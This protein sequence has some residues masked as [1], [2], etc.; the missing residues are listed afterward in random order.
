MAAK[1]LGQFLL[2]QGLIDR[3][4]LLDALEGQRAS[5]PLLGELAVACGM[6][7]GEQAQRI[8]ERQRREDLRFGDIAQS[9]GLLTAAQIETLLARQKAGSK[10]FGQILLEQGALTPDA[11]AEALKAHEAGRDEAID[12]L[13]AE[14][15]AH[16]AGAVMDNA[17]STCTRLFPRLLQTRCQFSSLVGADGADACRVTAHVRIDA[18]P[19]LMV[20]IGSD[21]ETTSNIGHAFLSLPAGE[22]DEALAQ[23][24]LGEL[25]NV[26]MGYV[27]KD[28]LADDAS[29]RASP[30]AFDTSVDALLAADRNALAVSM[31]SPL[32]AF[33]LLVAVG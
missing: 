14:V 24:A 16:P 17:I 7:D 30:P 26:L 3:Q 13:N 18:Q 29:Y 23:D 11:L 9:M 2:E 5:N 10:F 33:V 20:A 27:V 28:A 12:A 4:Q 25:V 32:G 6:L 21:P 31:A 19:P 22:C 1:F 8:N 15:A